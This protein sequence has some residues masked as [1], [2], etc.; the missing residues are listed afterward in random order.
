MCYWY[1]WKFLLIFSNDCFW[2]VFFFIFVCFYFIWWAGWNCSLVCQLIFLAFLGIMSFFFPI[3]L[4]IIYLSCILVCRNF[5][6]LLNSGTGENSIYVLLFELLEYLI[7]AS[8]VSCQV[9]CRWNITVFTLCQEVV[10][11]ILFAK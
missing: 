6:T 9:Q 3:I 5:Y 8:N 4:S 10:L 2:W 1:N 11:Y 7:R